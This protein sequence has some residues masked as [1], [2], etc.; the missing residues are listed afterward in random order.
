MRGGAVHRALLACFAGL[1]ERETAISTDQDT[2]RVART[3]KCLPFQLLVAGV[4][5]LGDRGITTQLARRRFAAV[6]AATGVQLAHHVGATRQHGRAIRCAR[7][8]VFVPTGILG[9][10]DRGVAECAL[11][12]GNAALGSATR[13]HGVGARVASEHAV[14]R[15]TD[16]SALIVGAARVTGVVGRDIATH[17]ALTLGATL[18][19][20]AWGLDEAIALTLEFQRAAQ[21]ASL[22]FIARATGARF[23][24]KNQQKRQ[25]Y[26]GAKGQGTGILPAFF[27]SRRE[28]LARPAWRGILPNP[29]IGSAGSPFAEESHGTSH[30]QHRTG[31]RARLEHG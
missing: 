18:G 5:Q 2:G 19:P 28:P 4:A 25:Q 8:E 20:A 3:R 30:R 31:L 7:F 10:G 24:R 14:L 23:A 12:C 29:R 9:L 27:R 11:V 15:V 17:A 6:R 21:A 13:N 22:A 1:I 16:R 26:R